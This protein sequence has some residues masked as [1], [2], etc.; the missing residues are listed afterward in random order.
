MT[1]K[2]VVH[3]HSY[4]I[5]IVNIV[6]F[7][8]A[9]KRQKK[10]LHQH[11]VPTLIRKIIICL[12]KSVKQKNTAVNHKKHTIIGWMKHIRHVVKLFVT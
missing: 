4:T 8:F 1:A 2:F 10:P 3:M 5:C 12:G 11:I 7:N 9:T 6:S